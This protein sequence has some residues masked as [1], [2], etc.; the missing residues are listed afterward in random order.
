MQPPPDHCSSRCAFTNAGQGVL[1]TVTLQNMGNSRL[2]GVNVNPVLALDNGTAV[3]G[4]GNW[5]CTLA[6][7]IEHGASLVCS[8]SFNFGISDIEAG[9]M[10]FAGTAAATSVTD[11]P[12][13]VAASNVTVTNA[14]AL[15]FRVDAAVCNAPDPTNF[16]GSTVTCTSTVELTNTGESSW[17]EQQ[18][19][20]AVPHLY[21][22]SSMSTS[23]VTSPQM[24]ACMRDAWMIEQHQVRASC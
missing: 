14:P 3:T 8:A 20:Q 11:I 19:L 15:T 22:N 5:D 6:A 1:Y 21:D 9:S 16:A 18:A 4:L 7:V 13:T 17:S 2:R 12:I 23:V 10:Y 24:W